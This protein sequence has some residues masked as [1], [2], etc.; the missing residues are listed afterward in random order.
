MERLSAFLDHPVQP[1][2]TERI[3]QHCSFAVMKEN[4]MVNGKLVPPEV[5]DFQKGQFM[6]KGP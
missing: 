1:D 4:D 2:Q 5:M 6:R 3:L